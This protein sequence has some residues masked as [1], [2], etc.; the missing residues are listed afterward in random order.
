MTD[1]PQHQELKLSKPQIV[2]TRL[3]FNHV[4]IIIMIFTGTALLA[5]LIVLLEKN[6]SILNTLHIKILFNVTFTALLIISTILSKRIMIP[7]IKSR[8]NKLLSKHDYLSVEYQ[9][10]TLFSS[11]KRIAVITFMQEFAKILIERGHKD[12]TIRSCPPKNI[13]TINPFKVTFEPLLL[14]ESDVTI[15]ELENTLNTDDPSD[16]SVLPAEKNLVTGII[17]NNLSRNIKITGGWGVFILL[18]ICALSMITLSFVTGQGVFIASIIPICL[19]MIV[20]GVRVGTTLGRRKWL[21]VPGGLIV[22]EGKFFS[23]D[24]QL[25]LFDRR[26][27]VLIVH[28]IDKHKWALFAATTKTFQFA[29]VTR[30]ESELLLRAWLSPIPPPPI[31]QLSDLM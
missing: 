23:Q 4:K 7:Q 15:R 17:P 30:K 12:L 11:N 28:R 21:I 9:I 16:E 20:S 5:I 18:V 2:D 6:I 10:V 27:S 3:R 29:V 14:D 1:A 13:V 19:I 8:I 31:E 24:C 26:T 25:H 22:R